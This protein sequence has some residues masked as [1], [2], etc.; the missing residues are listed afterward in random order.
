MMER[1]MNIATACLLV[2]VAGLAIP[3]SSQELHDR[4]GEPDLERFAVRP[5]ISLTLQYGPDH[6]ACQAL[7]EAPQPLI[8]GDEQ[9]SLI[10]SEGVSDVLEEV[11]PT[12]KRGKQIGK[13]TTQS[14]SIVAELTD[15]ENVTIMR[16]TADSD[17][18]SSNRD[19]RTSI[20]FKRAACPK[21]MAAIAPS[22]H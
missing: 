17:T 6:L 4:Y 11:V 10:S 12:A 16:T 7:I 19:L 20:S 14:G 1:A 22:Q 3:Q 18:S 5:G 2:A 8:R 15:Y 21:P 9:A 13:V